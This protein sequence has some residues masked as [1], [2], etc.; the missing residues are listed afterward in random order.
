MAEGQIHLFPD[1]AGAVV[2]NMAKSLFFPVEV[3][4]EMLGALGEVEDGVEID[5]LGTH[6]L[7]GGILPGQQLQVPPVLRFKGI[8]LRHS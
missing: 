4:H 1:D 2:E 3:A 7:D 8:G 6:S 5:Q